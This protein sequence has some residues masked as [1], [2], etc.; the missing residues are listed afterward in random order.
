MSHMKA[1]DPSTLEPIS[2]VHQRNLHPLLKGPM[3]ASHAKSEPVTGDVFNHNLNL[4][5]Q[6]TYMVFKTS[7][8][9]G[10]TEILATISAPDVKPAYIHSFFL[11]QNFVILTI[12]SAHLAAGGL[13]ILWEMNVLDAISSFSPD[14]AVKWFVVGRRHGRGV[15]VVFESPAA[16]CFHTINAYEKE[17][18][19]NGGYVDLICDLIEYDN[20][21][22]MHKGYYENMLSSSPA[23]AKWTTET[24]DGSGSHFARY[25]LASIPSVTSLPELTSKEGEQSRPPPIS[26]NA[27]RVTMIP[28][29]TSGDLPTI[30]PLYATKA[31]RFFWNCTFNMDR[32]TFVDGLCKVD[33]LTGKGLNWDNPAGQ[34]PGEATFIPNPDGQDEDDGALLTVVLDGFKGTSYLLCLDARTMEET[35]RADCQG[36]LAFMFHVQHVGAAGARAL[37]V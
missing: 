30:N 33:T 7:T 17:V 35:G 5:S 19:G 27:K 2:I 10:D 12:W 36:P 14:K 3:G 4:G 23:A 9:T 16:F 28:S 24:K 15:V 22:V 21:D 37:D 25:S 11:S 1:L 20:L 34:S 32:S 6:S 18:H 13:K 29:P 8:S 26:R 31:Y